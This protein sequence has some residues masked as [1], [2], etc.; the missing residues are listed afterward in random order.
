VTLRKAQSLG[1]FF[2]SLLIWSTHA[3]GVSRPESLSTRYGHPAYL[4]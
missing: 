3:C 1:R 2:L 4:L